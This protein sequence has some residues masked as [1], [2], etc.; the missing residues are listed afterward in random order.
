MPVSQGINLLEA[1]LLHLAR[2]KMRLA[3]ILESHTRLNT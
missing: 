3:M 1:R 2:N